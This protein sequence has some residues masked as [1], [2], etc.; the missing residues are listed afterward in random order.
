METK[1]QQKFGEV[2]CKYPIH[3]DDIDGVCEGALAGTNYWCTF[4]DV[5]DYKGAE[6]LTHVISSG[7]EWWMYVDKGNCK[8]PDGHVRPEIVDP[9]GRIHGTMG[10]IDPAEYDVFKLTAEKLVKGFQ[11]YKDNNPTAS[12]DPC[13]I[14]MGAADVIVQYALFGEQVFC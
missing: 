4:V 3:T 8:N 2:V 6:Y 7:G 10:S 13:D 1:E 5:P 14:D 9:D 11:L 12:L